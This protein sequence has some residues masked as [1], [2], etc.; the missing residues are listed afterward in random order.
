MLFRSLLSNSRDAQVSP[1]APSPLESSKHQNLRNISKLGVAPALPRASKDLESQSD[2]LPNTTTRKEGS[3]S[4]VAKQKRTSADAGFALAKNSFFVGK[5]SA[6]SASAESQ[7]KS[8]QFNSHSSKVPRFPGLSTNAGN[9]LSAI[10]EELESTT[11]LKT[12]VGELEEKVTNLQNLAIEAGKDAIA[13]QDSRKL[14]AENA[15]LAAKLESKQQ[16]LQSLEEKNAQ[17]FEALQ[18]ATS[19]A[20]DKEQETEALKSKLLSLLQP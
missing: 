10:F 17:L 13:R 16:A 14:I 3:S 19:K 5:L 15:A 4:I 18:G 1:Q 12:L 7:S 20:R 8:E 2:K 6:Q 9:A 11:A